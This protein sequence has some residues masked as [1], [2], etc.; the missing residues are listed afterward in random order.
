MIKKLNIFIFAIVVALVLSSCSTKVR[1]KVLVPPQNLQVAKIKKVA[2]LDFDGNDGTSFANFLESTLASIYVDENPYFDVVERRNMTKLFDE[3]K[4]QTS[5]MVA[6]NVVKAGKLIGAEGVFFGT[7]SKRFEKVFYTKKVYTCIK[8]DKK[9]RCIEY[10][11]VRVKCLKR[12][13]NYTVV[14]K[15]V[16]VSSGKIIYSKVLRSE[17]DFK[18][19]EGEK[20]EFTDSDLLFSARN[21]VLNEIKKDIAPYY[22][23]QLVEIM[24]EDEGLKSGNLEKQFE[25]AVEFAKSGRFD[26]ACKIW[27]ELLNKRKTVA[28]YYNLGVCSEVYGRLNTAL[29]YYIKAD[30]L[31]IK[32]DEMVNES[33]L[34]IKRKLKDR[35]ILQKLSNR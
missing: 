34:R 17:K 28:I 4:F 21:V 30:N 33:L 3:V 13:L 14:P 8:M 9:R 10:K 31:L 1:V 22:V 35:K 12:V 11:P 16:E 2:V 26:R 25:G 20:Q 15:L 18:L 24:D 7:A 23:N 19:C 29:E 6:E 32:P 5:G 27:E